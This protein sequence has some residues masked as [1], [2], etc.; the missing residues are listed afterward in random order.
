M[1]YVRAVRAPLDMVLRHPRS[2]KAFEDY[3]HGQHAD[4]NILFWSAAQEFRA[5]ANA[6]MA[7]VGDGDDA[8]RTKALKQIKR[9]GQAL[10][11]LYCEP[12][13]ELEMSLDSTTINQIRD[14]LHPDDKDK[15][16]DVTPFLFDAA[17]AMAEKD[18][19]EPH[20]RWCQSEKYRSYAE[21]LYADTSLPQCDGLNR[22]E[23]DLD[24]ILGNPLAM[25]IFA[26]Y[27]YKIPK[28]EG[29]QQ[30]C[31][32]FFR[33]YKRFQEALSPAV[34]GQRARVMYEHFLKS[35]DFDK[36]SS[37]NNSNSND[38]NDNDESKAREPENSRRGSRGH[39]DDDGDLSDEALVKKYL[40][41]SAK[42]V[43]A[44]GRHGKVSPLPCDVLGISREEIK[45]IGDV[46]ELE[47][48][49]SHSKGEVT[50]T[51]FDDIYGKVYGFLKKPAFGEFVSSEMMYLLAK[52]FRDYKQKRRQARK[53]AQA[54]VSQ[55]SLAVRPGTPRHLINSPRVSKGLENDYIM[56]WDE[57]LSS[58]QMLQAFEEFCHSE[59][60][61]ENILFF[62]EASEYR[63]KLHYK[64][65]KLLERAI[66][67][68]ELYVKEG[69][70]FE[71][72][73]DS[74]TRTRI[75]K[76]LQYQK[77][78]L[79]YEPEMPSRRGMGSR[80][81]GSN[82]APSDLDDI[83]V[84]T[85]ESSSDADPAV[86][87]AEHDDDWKLDLPLIKIFDEAINGIND[88]MKKDPYSRF[89]KSDYYFNVL[90]E[91]QQTSQKKRRRGCF[92]FACIRKNSAHHL[93][94]ARPQSPFAAR[95]H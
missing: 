15:F 29:T 63:T 34:R 1:E 32:R 73:I 35:Y 46:V 5:K 4:E 72:A 81:R 86:S 37:D 59:H 67:I 22:F 93:A 56:S 71:V 79:G 45:A 80:R 95:R 84:E 39:D 66:D 2:F 92:A 20:R 53:S 8:A 61:E 60:S 77:V 52:A 65:D 76:R 54:T 38:D 36:K 27:L 88:V 50:K 43:R 21:M 12:D 24:L 55:L 91:M 25:E 49:G 78:K 51:I 6:L 14:M 47:Q 74:H 41:P 42:G 44:S 90:Q 62:K 19:Q 3:L 10:W 28:P 89:V 40:T 68:Y 58:A 87:L 70:T 75:A 16:E 69:S 48:D 18:L 64:L 83:A 31:I 23:H 94:H 11:Q 9:M 7:G 26:D 85:D 13:A 33:H 82:A 30:T 17:Q 57:V